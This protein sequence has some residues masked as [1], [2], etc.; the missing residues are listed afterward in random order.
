MFYFRFTIL[1]KQDNLGGT[2]YENRWTQHVNIL[3]K[4]QKRYH[5]FTPHTAFFSGPK[6]TNIVYFLFQIS[7]MCLWY[8]KS[9]LQLFILPG[10]ISHKH[11]LLFILDSIKKKKKAKFLYCASRTMSNLL[12]C[13]WRGENIS[14]LTFSFSQCWSVWPDSPKCPSS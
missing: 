12:D 14:N 2:W 5:Q 6:L 8:S 11:P 10:E 3:F 13:F 1:E 7:R 9:P 4:K